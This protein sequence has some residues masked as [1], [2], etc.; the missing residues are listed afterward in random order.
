M[1]TIERLNAKDQN[2]TDVFATTSTDPWHPPCKETCGES[3]PGCVA[4][5]WGESMYPQ[6]QSLLNRSK[7]G[8]HI[9][10]DT[11]SSNRLYDIISSG[12]V[13]I[14]IGEKM[15]Q[16]LPFQEDL[17]WDDLVI[18]VDQEEATTVD[19]LQQSG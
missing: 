12:A 7:F 17:P 4:C 5:Y 10:G 16:S 19:G 9:G 11:A 3:P 13:P 8:W 14:I 1:N 2:S 6:Y 18:F 15:T